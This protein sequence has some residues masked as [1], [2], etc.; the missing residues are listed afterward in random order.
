M[1]VAVVVAVTCRLINR[2]WEFVE[3]VSEPQRYDFSTFRPC[4]CEVSIEE[5][6]CT[7]ANFLLTVLGLCYRPL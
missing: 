2:G 5:C 3:V 6:L 1:F 4:F 7:D